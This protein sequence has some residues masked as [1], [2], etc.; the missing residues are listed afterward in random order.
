M[1]VCLVLPVHFIGAGAARPAGVELQEG[2]ARFETLLASVA[3][4]ERALPD[5]YWT[6]GDLGFELAFED[7]ETIAAWVASSTAFQ[8]YRGVLRGAD[9]TLQAR[10]GNAF[11][12]ALLLT[13]LLFDAGYE[14]RIARTTLDEAAA[15]TLLR[16]AAS[17]DAGGVLDDGALERYAERIGGDLSEARRSADAAGSGVEERVA[18]L[19]SASDWLQATLTAAGIALGDEDVAA[20]LADASDYA[21][22]QYRFGPNDPWG[23]L[24]PAAPVDAPWTD[25]LVA[26]SVIEDAVPSEL[27]HSFRVQAMIERRRGDL[28]EVEPVSQAW[29]RPVAN[30]NGVALRYE[31]VPDGFVTLGVDADPAEAYAA[32]TYLLPLFND[33]LAPGELVFDTLGNVA[34]AFA[35]ASAAGGLFGT[36]SQSLGGALDAV[37][38][39]DDVVALTAHWLEFTFIEPGGAEITHRRMIVDR[40]GPTRRAAGDASGPL[41]QMSDDELYDALRT[42][43]TFMLAPGRYSAGFVQERSVAG[44]R[45]G[46]EYLRD[47]FVAAGD[48]PDTVP[49]PSAEYND[50]LHGAPLLR[51]LQSFDENPHLE[52]D[53]LVSYRPSP[54]L[55]VRTASWDA[56]EVA[57]DVVRNV[58]RVLH[59]ASDGAVSAAPEA[60]LREG[61]WESAVEAMALHD[62]GVRHDTL[63]YFEA[64]A[65]AGTPVR[66]LQPGALADLDALT[67]PDDSLAAMRRDLERGYAVVTATAMPPGQSVAAWWRVNPR[68][69]ETL[70]RGGDGRGQAATEYTEMQM[71][72]A[73]LLVSAAFGVTGGATCMIGGGNVGCCALDAGLGLLAG[74]VIGLIVS[75]ATVAFA[76][77]AALDGAVA[78]GGVFSLAGLP[79][80]T[81]CMLVSDGEPSPH[82][83][84]LVCPPSRLQAATVAWERA[85]EAH[86]GDAQQQRRQ[87]L[88]ADREA[89][90]R[91][92]AV[93]EDIEVT[94]EGLGIHPA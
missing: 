85:R 9:G 6:V 61:V 53:G 43:H 36:L 90:V 93:L 80:P 32:T 76:A 58:R 27:L 7:A 88:G 28:L 29:E 18:G 59:V 14:A 83:V 72:A 65:A 16:S 92:H 2:I 41:L 55:V 38:G 17:G 30:L 24:H 45:V 3:E 20:A 77:A 62:G 26:E 68:T 15:L 69:G 94:G 19:A 1:T 54:T 89:A 33:N 56:R 44:M 37:A 73:G 71:T 47:V 10:A 13:S 60:A 86:V 91:R 63:S 82:R 51:L 23:A 21:W 75:S 78:L 34:P 35:A 11:D 22:V 66:V 84:A 70:G 57:V 49:M 67:V 52:R 42:K 64:V 31:A 12:Q 8:P 39:E 25:G 50:V 48:D 4:L 40:L 74:L 87:A 46:L 79:F 5:D 81:T